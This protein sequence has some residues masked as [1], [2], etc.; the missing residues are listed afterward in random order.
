MSQ[1]SSQKSP[2][3]THSGSLFLSFSLKMPLFL[4]LMGN[5]WTY[6]LEVAR[7]RCVFR[8][9]IA[10]GRPAYALVGVEWRLPAKRFNRRS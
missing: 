4:W 10:C 6:V 3:L 2:T 1:A 9:H 5:E 7:L 8:L